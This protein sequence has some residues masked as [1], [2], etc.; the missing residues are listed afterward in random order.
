MAMKKRTLFLLCSM[1]ALGACSYAG[2]GETEDLKRALNTT[3]VLVAAFLVFFMQAGFAMLEAGFTRAKNASNV[4]MKGVMDFCLTSLFY[5]AVGFGLMFGADRAGLF[6]T[7]GFFLSAAGPGTP[8]GLWQFAYWMFQVAFAGA[9][10]TI[11]AGAISERAKFGAYL[12]Y[13]VVV[14]VLIYPLAGHW[15][16]GGGWLAKLGMVDFAGSAV[17]HTVGGWAA[18]AA[19]MVVGP[20]YGKYAV[21][22]RPKAIPGHNIPLAALGVF[23]L[24]FGWF[25]FNPGSTLSGLNG[26]I[27]TIAVTTNLAACAGAVGAMLAAWARYGRP[28]AS[29]TLNGCLI[30]LVAITGGCAVVSPVAAVVIGLVAGIVVV[31]SVEFIDKVVKVDDPVGAVSVHGVGGLMGVLFIGLFADPAY[32]AAAGVTGVGGAPA[33]GLFYGGG[34]AQLGVQALGELTVIAWAFGTTLLLFAAMKR[35][36]GVRVETEH[37]LRGLDISE[38]ATEAYSGFQIFVTQ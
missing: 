33:A 28:D 22:G 6:G 20:R 32:S 31:L 35:T 5:W 25:G 19:A 23:I 30:G 10:A 18:F 12:V 15:I 4:I 13:T 36:I 17:V 3:W 27:G 2:A 29:M 16:W 38:H 26:S 34:L 21:D 14:A 24:W 9:A 11:V 7:T 8:D 37:Q 1:A